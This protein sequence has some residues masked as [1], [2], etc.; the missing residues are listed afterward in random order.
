MER[1]DGGRLGGLTMTHCPAPLVSSPMRLTPFSLSS[2]SGHLSTR[3]QPEP[4]PSQR[5]GAEGTSMRPTGERRE[6]R[7]GSLTV[8]AFSAQ[9]H[10]AHSLLVDI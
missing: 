10:C 9:T 8:G 6:R 5:C 2:L 1:R 7:A 3:R 4:C